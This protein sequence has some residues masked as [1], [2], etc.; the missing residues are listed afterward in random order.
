MNREIQEYYHE[1]PQRFAR[2]R[3]NE[4]LERVQMA[5]ELRHGRSFYETEGAGSRTAGIAAGGRYTPEPSTT[6]G[7]HP[8]DDPDNGGLVAELREL[9]RKRGWHP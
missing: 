8:Y 2:E 5:Q 7:N 6:A 4:Y 3:R 9:Q 1:V